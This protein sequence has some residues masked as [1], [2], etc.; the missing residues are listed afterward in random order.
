MYD[1]STISFTKGVLAAL[2][3]RTR[4]NGLSSRHS[5]TRIPSLIRPYGFKDGCRD[6]SVTVVYVF[7]DYVS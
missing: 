4:R 7:V 1:A 5:E 3:G 2:D 6:V